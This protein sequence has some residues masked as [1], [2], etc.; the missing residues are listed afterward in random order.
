[1]LIKTYIVLFLATSLYAFFLYLL[2]RKWDPDLT[3]V[4][5]AIGI[6]ICM[7]APMWL[8]RVGD[9][10]WE[11]YEAYTLIAFV[12]GG[13]PIAVGEAIRNRRAA[14]AAISEART[15][16]AKGQVHGDREDPLAE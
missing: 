16:V 6:A 1:M 11:T 14:E 7:A 2:K 15:L 13:F 12:V 10:G 3:W 9:I 8:A 5:V 4:E